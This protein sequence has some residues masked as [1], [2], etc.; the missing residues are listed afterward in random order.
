MTVMYQYEQ[1]VLGASYFGPVSGSPLIPPEIVTIY[2]V[3]FFIILAV[4]YF[5][6]HQKR[7]PVHIKHKVQLLVVTALVLKLFVVIGGGLVAAYWLVPR[8]GIQ[9]ITPLDNSKG[10][11]V[12]K[13]LEIIF[14]RPVSRNDLAKNISP[15][16]PGVWL[17]EDSLYTT[18]LYRKLVFYPTVSFKPSTKYTVS[19]SNIKN[20]IGLTDGYDQSFTFVTQD[21]PGISSVFPKNGDTNF[22]IG[23]NLKV[24]LTEPNDR[25]SEFDFLLTPSHPIEVR[26]DATKKIYTIIPKEPFKQGVKYQL[27]INKTNLSYNLSSNTI[28]ER[29]D[30]VKVYEGSF[31]T[32]DAPGIESFTVSETNFLPTDPIVITFSEAMDQVSTQD[33]FSITPAVAGQF[34]WKD[35]KAMTFKPNKLDFETKYTVK[36]AK[37]AKSQSS[38]FIE[39]DVVKSFTTIGSVKVEESYPVDKWDAVSIDA[40]IKIT[41]DQEVDKISAESQFTILPKIDGKFSWEGNTLIFKSSSPLLYSTT[42]KVQLKPG[43]KSIHGLDSAQDFSMSF[44]SQEQTV[45][46]AVPVMLQQHGLSCEVAALRMALSFRGVQVSEET[47]LAKVGVDNTPHNGDIWGD[48][49]EAFVGNVDGKQMVDGYGVYWGP[50]ERVAKE[51]RDAEDFEGWDISSLTQK[52]S[53]GNPVVIWVYS[54]GGW[55]TSW[56]TPSGKYITGTRDEHAVTAVGYVGPSS[57]PSQLIIN[58]PLHGQVYW[59]RALFDKKWQSFGKSG[60]VV[61]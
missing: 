19:L 25:V 46:L 24:D 10:H 1:D 41:F 30:T 2:F 11:E 14:D 57:N 17:F 42:Y 15:E 56:H 28:V 60:V 54:S 5:I 39:K 12:T 8:P 3:V 59:S 58:D 33:N 40:P 6:L 29:G 38:G 18:H 23:T 49:Y 52:I 51:Y 22:E 44:T 48:P 13:K 61:Y 7:K 21:P 55:P 37:G 26:L 45:K 27:S 20:V 47:L 32:K 34:T 36:I 9:S 31:T 43:I 35:D 50:I 4:A 53:E 16:V